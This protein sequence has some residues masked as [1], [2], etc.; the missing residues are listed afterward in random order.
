[1]HLA[2]A[3][4]PLNPLVPPS[5]RVRSR[6]GLQKIYPQ[7]LKK[8]KQRKE[9][10]KRK[11]EN[12]QT[13]YTHRGKLYTFGS[14][15][16][17]SNSSISLYT[18][19]KCISGHIFPKNDIQTS[20]FHPMTHDNNESILVPGVQVYHHPKTLANQNQ[21]QS[22]FTDTSYLFEWLA[23]KAGFPSSSIASKGNTQ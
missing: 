17:P 9:K 19:I 16:T 1:M 4:S 6:E 5:G 23:W 12:D 18:S 8:E 21:T 13:Q 2:Y 14:T 3:T 11:N 7:N 10:Q 15:K 20:A 22:H